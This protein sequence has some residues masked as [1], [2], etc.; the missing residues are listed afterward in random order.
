MTPNAWQ[1]R[2]LRTAGIAAAGHRCKGQGAT[3]GKQAV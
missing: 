3:R 2:L 1:V